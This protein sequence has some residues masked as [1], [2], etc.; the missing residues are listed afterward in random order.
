M[1]QSKFAGSSNFTGALARA[2]DI[3]H[4]VPTFK[5]INMETYSLMWGRIKLL[6]KKIGERDI[7]IG[8]NFIHICYK[9]YLISVYN[10]II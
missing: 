10:I 4:K 5:L 6:R 7:N 3:L 8:W 9:H 1:A 2:F